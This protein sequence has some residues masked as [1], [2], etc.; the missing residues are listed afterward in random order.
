[1]KHLLTKNQIADIN[2]HTQFRV[3]YNKQFRLYELHYQKKLFKKMVIYLHI[4]SAMDDRPCY[5]QVSGY[6]ELLD[7][8]LEAAKRYVATQE[9]PL[10][11]VLDFYNQYKRDVTVLDKLINQR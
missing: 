4:D 8:Q 10:Q 3:V 7:P 2:E 1:M 11:D 9:Y 5:R 6:N